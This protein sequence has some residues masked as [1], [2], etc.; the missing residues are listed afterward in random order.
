MDT[1]EKVA[2]ALAC[3]SMATKARIT[4]YYT[5]VLKNWKDEKL[6][7]EYTSNLKRGMKEAFKSHMNNTRRVLI[8]K[9]ALDG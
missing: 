6:Y 1:L 8:D 9:K 7:I 4:M 3:P 5:Y 2:K